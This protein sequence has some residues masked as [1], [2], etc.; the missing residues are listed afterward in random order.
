LFSSGTKRVETVA[1]RIIPAFLVEQTELVGVSNPR[2]APMRAR[3][4]PVDK[5]R[6]SL[7]KFFQ[8]PCPATPETG[9]FPNL[10][11]APRIAT[12]TADKIALTHPKPPGNPDIYRVRFS[13]RAVR[14][15]SERR[16]EI[17]MGHGRLIDFDLTQGTK[18]D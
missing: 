8:R 16:R 17:R 5:L 3:V 6:K 14:D 13:Q 18:A 15:S 10:V 2:Y 1:K 12:I 7:L 11:K 4:H 9:L